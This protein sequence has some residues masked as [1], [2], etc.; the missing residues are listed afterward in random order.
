MKILQVNTEKTWRGGERQTL[1]VCQGLAT[2]GCQVELL[3]REGYPLAE[4]AKAAG[5]TTHEVSNHRASF[6]FMAKKGRQYDVIHAQ[7]AKAQTNAVASKPFHKRPVVYTRRV[8]F[9]VKG[10]LSK[11]KYHQTDKLVAISEAIKDIMQRQGFTDISVIP[12]VIKQ[13]EL[14]IKRAQK[15]TEK[16]S[17]TAIQSGDKKIVATIAAMVP[18]KDPL[19]LI[20]AIAELKKLRSDFTFLHFGDG[21]LKPEVEKAI[22][23]NN[24]QDT[25]HMMGYVDKV[26]DFYSIFDVFVM[27]SQEEGLGSSVLDAFLYKVPVASTNAGG[28]KETVDGRGLLSPKHNPKALA[29]NINKL[30]DD[31]S[32]VEQLTT[33]AYTEV[34]EN[35]SLEKTTQEY[36]K[37]YRDLA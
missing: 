4:Q 30:L 3:C 5:I 13:Q 17:P 37:I 7:S 18:H 26:E 21:K 24:L 23:A 34:L 12:S 16:L 2:A 20:A 22:V 36:L 1:Y 11:W 14:D 35:Y 19:T 15:I 6:S 8:D 31:T 25:Y 28:L 33:K 32:L 9:T 29:D 10:Q 27:S